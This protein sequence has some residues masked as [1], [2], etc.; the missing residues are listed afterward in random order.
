M[1]VYISYANEDQR[2]L[3]QCRS[4]LAPLV[5]DGITEMLSLDEKI[6]PG[7]RWQQEIEKLIDAADVAILLVSQSYFNSTYVMESELPALLRRLLDRRRVIPVLVEPTELIA[8]HYRDERHTEHKLDLDEIGFLG[9]LRDPLSSLSE[10]DQAKRWAELAE[11][12][13][14]LANTRTIQI[15]DIAWIEIPAGSFIYGEHNVADKL[16]LDTFW[17]AKYPITN[18]QYQ[19][20][21]DDGGYEDEHWWQ[22]L[23]KP[24]P[25]ASRWSQANRP[26]TNVDWYEAVAFTRWF[27]TRLGFDNFEIRLPTEQ[28]WEKAAR[29]MEGLDY[30]WGDH[31]Q[32]GFANLDETREKFGPWYIEQTTAVGLYPQGRSPYQIHDAS[33]TVWEWCL[34]KYEK[35]ETLEAD[36]SGDPRVLRGGSWIVSPDEARTADRIRSLPDLRDDYRGF[37]VVSSVPIRDR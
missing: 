18:S 16:H 36:R 14:Q 21:I 6:Q 30:P 31:H 28:Q 32:S 24:E 11:L 23:V 34:N 13:A 5:D 4:A 15:P 35:T 22:S 19:T 37:R 27:S 3:D 2:H 17:I 29:G 26:R 1:K 9:G 8:V 25:E 7:Q 10:E 33:G 12:L 20:F